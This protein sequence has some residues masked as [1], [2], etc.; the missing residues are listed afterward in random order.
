MVMMGFNSNYG[1]SLTIV[2]F[3][4]QLWYFNG[5]YWLSL[6]IMGFHWELWVHNGN[7]WFDILVH[8]CIFLFFFVTTSDNLVFVVAPVQ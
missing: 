3:H 6:G 1:F 2:G 5:N 8:S 4:W 7:H